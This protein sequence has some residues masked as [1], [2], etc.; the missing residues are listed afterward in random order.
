MN[1]GSPTK[2]AFLK[3]VAEVAGLTKGRE[4]PARAGLRM[5]RQS[6]DAPARSAG[7]AARHLRAE[8]FGGL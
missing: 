7:S 4:E 1:D 2:A 6:A 8:G 5:L 3:E